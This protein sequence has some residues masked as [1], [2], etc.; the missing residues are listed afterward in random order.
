MEN[1]E[2]QELFYSIITTTYN[3]AYILNKLFNSLLEQTYK[4]FE[5]VIGDDGS[6]DETEKLVK[7][8]KEKANFIIRYYKLPHRGKADTWKCIYDLSEGQYI[9]SIDSDDALYDRNSLGMMQEKILSLNPND[10]FWGVCGSYVDQNGRVFPNLDFDY[11]DITKDNFFE[12]WAEGSPLLNNK[13]IHKKMKDGYKAYSHPEV[14]EFLPYYP[15]VVDFMRNVAESKDFKYR[16]FN[17]KLIDYVLHGED[18][19]SLMQPSLMAWYEIIGMINLFYKHNLHK[20]YLS[21]IQ[22]KLQALKNGLYKE[23]GFLIT[24]ISLK[25]LSA[26]IDFLNLY[27]KPQNIIKQILSIK[28]EYSNNKKYKVLTILGIKIKFKAAETIARVERER[29]SKLPK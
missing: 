5:W 20:K 13:W 11:F 28:N 14:K 10:N 25:N 23:K 2:K 19:V 17:V 7:S 15:E 3:R 1:I 24:L 8:F 6:T 4:N 18:C 26:K 9:L 21:Q 16:V 12:L 27:I 22:N 29:E